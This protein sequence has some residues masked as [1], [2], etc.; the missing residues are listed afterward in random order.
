[1]TAIIGGKADGQ[2][3]PMKVLQMELD[4]ETYLLIGFKDGST[5][6]NF[7]MPAGGIPAEAYKT[8]RDRQKLAKDPWPPR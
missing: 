5:K 6:G 7:Y 2:F 4:G 3:S 8:Y 1:M